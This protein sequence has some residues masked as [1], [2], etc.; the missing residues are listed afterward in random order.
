LY[1]R[2]GS[3]IFGKQQQVYEIRVA[4]LITGG[5]LTSQH[6]WAHG[7]IFIVVGV[8]KG[9]PILFRGKRKKG[10]SDDAAGAGI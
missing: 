9:H 10:K 3:L 7:D 1:I 2:T 5:Y 6:C 8:E 4:S